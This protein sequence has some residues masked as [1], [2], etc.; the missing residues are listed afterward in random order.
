[1]ALKKKGG[2]AVL[3]RHYDKVIVV[4][5]LIGLLVSLLYLS[6]SARTVQEDAAR[7]DRDLSSLTPKY[8]KADPVDPA[9]FEKAQAMLASPFQMQDATNRPFVVPQERVWCV[10]CRRPILFSADACPFCGKDQ[11]GPG[12][13]SGWDSDG[14][15]IP[16]LVETQYG[17]NP[18]D[19]SDIH[20]DADGDGFTN[21]EEHQAKT[22][23]QDPASHPPRIAFLRIKEIAALPFPLVLRGAMRGGDG[24]VR[25]Q[26]NDRTT[27][28]SHFNVTEGQT[29]GKTGYILKSGSVRKVMRKIEGYV[30]ER[31]VEIP[32]VNV[33]R[34][35]G[36]TIML[37]LDTPT[38]GDYVVT[39]VCTK[40][41]T[42]T[43]YTGRPD[44]A[45]TFDGEAYE[46]IKIDTAKQTVV[47][48]RVSDKEEIVVPK[49]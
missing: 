30:E 37:L 44:E 20:H 42:A 27:G 12:E 1:M 11:P 47:I 35:G 28:Q 26:V 31:E 46:V 22:N 14:D 15:G 4:V 40:D 24:K 17:M 3:H 39:F 36:R 45:F 38:E 32:V 9:P 13:S 7:F 43:D 18:L 16:D 49:S 48:R 5:I 8:P 29:I 10:E 33:Q 6:Q 41:R 19:P 2:L 25:Y 23:L 21:L 34:E